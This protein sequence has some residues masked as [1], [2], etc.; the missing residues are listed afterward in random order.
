MRST[1]P[2]E[3][4]IEAL[5]QLLSTV[6]KGVDE[7]VRRTRSMESYI[8][9]L[10]RS[11]AT[12]NCSSRTRFLCRTMLDMRANKW[13]PRR[14]ELKAKKLDEIHAEAEATLGLRSGAVAA[15][16]RLGPPRPG[17]RPMPGASPPPGAGRRCVVPGIG[18]PIP[19]VDL[20]GWETVGIGRRGAEGRAAAAPRVGGA[21]GIC[22]GPAWARGHPGH[23]APW[24]WPLGW[25]LGWALAWA[26][27]WGQAWALRMGP[28]MG[29]QS[30]WH[31]PGHGL[32]G[33]AWGSPVRCW[34]LPPCRPCSRRACACPC[35]PP[36]AAAP[37]RSSGK[38]AAASSGTSARRS[39]R[40]LL[41]K[42]SSSRPTSPT[43][44][45][46][47]RRSGRHASAALSAGLCGVH[48]AGR[49]WT[50]IK[51]KERGAMWKL[52]GYLE[53]KKALE[54][55]RWQGALVALAQE[56][57]DLCMDA[58]N[59]PKYLGDG[60]ALLTRSKAVKGRRRCWR[61]CRG[62]EGRVCARGAGG[63]HAQGAGGPGSAAGR[64]PPGVPGAAGAEAHGAGNGRRVGAGEAEIK[65]LFGE[66]LAKEQLPASLLA[67]DHPCPSLPVLLGHHMVPVR[68]LA[69]CSARVH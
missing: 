26:L 18:A 56:L 23:A 30:G 54:G 4:N 2:T 20:D 45:S 67:S 39:A 15:G 35:S 7:R 16:L 31:G 40:T 69:G 29:G 61:G 1:E 36:Q 52:L 27:G 68:L 64:T 59:A 62:G 46:T 14:Q 8:G 19:G 13:V 66:A 49:P 48:D 53:E 3:E 44:S 33:I 25:A 51:E 60:L 42:E 11:R 21:R 10:S 43:P 34:A 47:P 58:P 38:R 17:A 24:A 6:G 28:G 22:R 5:C 57:E 50:S 65:E 55:R 32:H 41:L 12:R 63:A 9:E 37:A